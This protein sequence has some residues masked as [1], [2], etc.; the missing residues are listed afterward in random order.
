MKRS[1]SRRDFLKLGGLSLAG[2]ALRGFTPDFSRFDD[3]SLI[4]VATKSVSVYSEPSDQS[5][6]TGSWY[7]D[8]LVHVYQ[9]VVAEEPKWNPV[10]FRVWGGYLHRGRIQR[11]KVLPNL[12]PAPIP[13]GKRM[14]AEVS[15]PWTQP[16]R[17]TKTYGWQPLGFR[18]YY[19]SV[20]L[21]E[22]IEAGP[23]KETWQAASDPISLHWF[24]GSDQ[25]AW[26]RI[27]DDLTG[28]P[29]FAPA[30]ALRPIPAESLAPISPEVPSES[31][32][33]DVN[34]TTQNLTAYE[35]DKIVFQT[36]VS[37][38]IPGGNKDTPRGTFH[39]DPK[40]PAKHMG[41]GNLFA[42]VDDYELPGV[43]WTSFFTEAGHA[44]HG[45]YWHEN[46]GTPMSHGC[47]NM[48]TNEAKWLFRWSR[49]LSD[50]NILL[51][52][53]RSRELHGQGTTVEIH[54]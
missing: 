4:R 24:G 1:L 23:D 45:T 10:W 8:D 14:L 11:V 13:E 37:S 49:P 20:H 12:P 50:A 31:K 53:T 2:L 28:F 21:V 25:T 16:W 36:K 43:P 19:E 41:N 52:S 33:L 9:E 34:L 6:I 38:G 22:A 40:T 17:Y 30:M 47:L 46:F 26:Y 42:D 32:R 39:I 15:L 44:F 5:L 29:Y 7:R 51:D 27:Y 3:S 54:Y 18:L 48:R 35:Y